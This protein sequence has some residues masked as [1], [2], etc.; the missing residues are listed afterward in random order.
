MPSMAQHEAIIPVEVFVVQS[1]ANGVFR[2]TILIAQCS[3]Q[4][5]SVA[6]V[7]AM[8]CHHRLIRLT[9]M[10]VSPMFIASSLDGSPFGPRIHCHIHKEFGIREG[11]S[12]LSRP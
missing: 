10:D 6:E 2:K 9:E 8:L 11:H 1:D 5:D 3:V 4:N 7:D 12:N